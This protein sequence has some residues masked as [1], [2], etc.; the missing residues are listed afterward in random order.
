MFADHAS[1]L[2]PIDVPREWLWYLRKRTVY[3]GTSI[4]TIFRGIYIDLNDWIVMVLFISYQKKD[5][6]LTS[7][8]FKVYQPRRFKIVSGEVM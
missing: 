4:P 7:Y 3:F 6:V 2:N 1:S 5:D 8:F